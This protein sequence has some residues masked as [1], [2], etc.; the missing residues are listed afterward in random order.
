MSDT[1]AAYFLVLCTPI[2]F[3]YALSTWWVIYDLS[4][5]KNWHGLWMVVVCFI[6]MFIPTDLIINKVYP[7][8][9]KIDRTLTYQDQLTKFVHNYDRSNPITKQEAQ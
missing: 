8:Q 9:V 4:D 1:M 2:S 3:L 6:Y 7:I 5:G